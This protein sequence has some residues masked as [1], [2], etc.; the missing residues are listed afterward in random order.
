L[1]V[2]VVVSC[3]GS[4]RVLDWS[5]G[6]NLIQYSSGASLQ[7]PAGTA[8]SKASAQAQYRAAV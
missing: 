6:I 5:M 3:D 2:D 7:Q 1:I 4:L 8:R